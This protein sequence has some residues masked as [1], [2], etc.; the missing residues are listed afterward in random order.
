MVE[1]LEA[2]DRAPA[3]ADSI[4]D[5]MYNDMVSGDIHDEDLLRSAQKDD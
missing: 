3:A 4:P 1:S 5:Q 2:I